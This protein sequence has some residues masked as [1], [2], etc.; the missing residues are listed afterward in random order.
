[1]ASAPPS[2]PR[3]WWHDFIPVVSTAALLMGAAAYS[4][5]VT[6][7]LTEVE[8]QV[9]DLK[10]R[11][12]QRDKDQEANIDKLNAIDGRTIRIET[13]LLMLKPEKDK[14]P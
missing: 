1:M 4:G 8:K 7:R 3:P 2:T 12:D 6:Q 13:T 11:E 10:A 5:G 14:A 9:I